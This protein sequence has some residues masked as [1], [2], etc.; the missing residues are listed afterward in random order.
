MELI[1]WAIAGVLLALFIAGI[2]SKTKHRSDINIT[3]KEEPVKAPKAPKLSRAERLEEKK[4][5]AEYAKFTQAH[6]GA[7][8]VFYYVVRYSMRK[9]GYKALV[10]VGI[11]KPE[12]YYG[13]VH[14]GRWEI[15]EADIQSDIH[16]KVRE[17]YKK[18][19]II[20]TKLQ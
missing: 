9:E 15:V 16:K 2:G 4:A 17:Q 14:F 19:D 1:L 12:N 3:Y 7:V 13:F 18:G 20:I 6:S 5:M 8:K 10:S 11:I